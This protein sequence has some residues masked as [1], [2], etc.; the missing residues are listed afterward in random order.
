MLHDEFK[1]NTKFYSKDLYLI[2]FLTCRYAEKDIYKTDVFKKNFTSSYLPPEICYD[3]SYNINSDMW[4]VGLISYNL[5]FREQ[6]LVNMKN[7]IKTELDTKCIK[8]DFFDLGFSKNITELLINCFEINPMKR[9]TSKELYD[10]I[11]DD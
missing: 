11:L 1:L 10:C 4:G 9:T 2:D 3:N 6:P 5:L 7:K 8:R